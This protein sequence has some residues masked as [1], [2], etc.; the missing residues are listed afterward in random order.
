MTTLETGREA[1]AYLQKFVRAHTKEWAELMQGVNPNQSYGRS[2][3]AFRAWN[4]AM[5]LS[6]YT[7]EHFKTAS[8]WTTTPRLNISGSGC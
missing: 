5:M 1:A 6:N 2:D 8:S 4:I 7:D 3:L